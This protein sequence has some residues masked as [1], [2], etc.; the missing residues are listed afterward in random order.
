MSRLETWRCEELFLPFLTCDLLFGFLRKKWHLLILPRGFVSRGFL[1][2]T[3][4]W[5]TSI[6]DASIRR[7]RGGWPGLSM[8]ALNMIDSPKKNEGSKSLHH[9]CCYFSEMTKMNRC[10][11]ATQFLSHIL[12]LSYARMGMNIHKDELI[13]EKWKLKT[14]F[15]HHFWSTAK[16]GRFPVTETQQ[17]IRCF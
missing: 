4:S 3:N 12:M 8:L 14:S 2:F 11:L 13:F 5:T 10:G 17:I 15:P 7:S 6:V 16:S 9:W 1:R